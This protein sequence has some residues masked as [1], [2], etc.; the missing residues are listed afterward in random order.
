MR[1]QSCISISRLQDALELARLWSVCNATESELSEM[2]NQLA[3]AFILC[4]VSSRIGTSARTRFICP[5]TI[6]GITGAT[7]RSSR[8]DFICAF[9]RSRRL[10]NCGISSALRT[11]KHQA[12][13]LINTLRLPIG[14][15]RHILTICPRACQS[16]NTHYPSY[17]SCPQHAELGA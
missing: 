11:N 6:A 10:H 12:M 3:D 9:L 8:A 7:V 5:N 16:D 17:T 14:V 1:L 2:T 4:S 15:L 13:G